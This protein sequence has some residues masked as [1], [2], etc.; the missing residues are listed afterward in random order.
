MLVGGLARVLEHVMMH[1]TASTFQ[2]IDKY[3]ERMQNYFHFSAESHVLALTPLDRL[4]KTHP[5]VFVC[6]LIC[7]RL[8][9]CSIV[10]AATSRVYAKVLAFYVKELKTLEKSVL[11]PL[12]SSLLVWPEDAEAYRHILREAVA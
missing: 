6:A 10:L 7:K 12:R 5:D 9:A 4:I 2:G 11:G 3:L 1:F 8:R